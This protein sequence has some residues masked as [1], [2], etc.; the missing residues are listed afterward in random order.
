MTYPFLVRDK[1]AT[2]NPL[3]IVYIGRLMLPVALFAIALLGA[4]A[5]PA[6]A[7][8]VQNNSSLLGEP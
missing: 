8:T 2:R 7:Q 5:P 6:Q 4:L 1:S 3:W